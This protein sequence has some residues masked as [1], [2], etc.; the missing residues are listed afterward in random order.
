MNTAIVLAGGS[1]KRMNSDIPKQYLMLAGKPVIYYSLK[2]FQDNSH[3]D[4]IIL[5]T[6]EEY[7]DYA[8][9]NILDKTLSKVSM[10]VQG[11]M[12][13]YDSVYKGLQCIKEPG[14]VFIH[15]GARPCISQKLIDDCYTNVVKNGACIAAVPVKDTIKIAD[16]EGF[17]AETPDRSTLWQIQTPQ[18]FRYDIIKESYDKLYA[19]GRFNGVTDD[20]M[21]LERYGEHRIKL[22]NS[23]YRNIK[24]TTPEDMN[25]A[26]IFIKDTF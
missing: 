6:A 21:V 19:G 10:V 3:I 23:D 4:N 18:V 22:V 17:A 16:A 20:A 12:E 2:A 5:V 11:G 26:E 14:Y 15:D 8:K 1:G 24:I 7:I 13:R 25:T 9:E